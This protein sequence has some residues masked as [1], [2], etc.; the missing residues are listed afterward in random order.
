MPKKCK[1]HLLAKQVSEH[2]RNCQTLRT[3]YDSNLFSSCNF[4]VCLVLLALSCATGLGMLGL[5]GDKVVRAQF[6]KSCIDKPPND[7][8]DE[9]MCVMY[10]A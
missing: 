3:V 1:V 10:A 9:P 4:P 2:R 7:S 6:A 8:Q 5:H